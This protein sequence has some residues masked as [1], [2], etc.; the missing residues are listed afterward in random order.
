MI[1]L[2]VRPPIAF[3]TVQDAAEN[4]LTF[5]SS[6][7]FFKTRW[8]YGDTMNEAFEERVEEIIAIASMLVD[9]HRANERRKVRLIQCCPVQFGTSWMIGKRKSVT[10]IEVGMELF[11][12]PSAL[13]GGSVVSLCNSE[14]VRIGYLMQPDVD[15]IG[16]LMEGGHD[17]KSIVCEYSEGNNPDQ[18]LR[19]QKM[20]VLIVDILQGKD[21]K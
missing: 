11:L 8:F 21:L 18:K 13:N 10:D 1:K 2:H 4:T 14:G 20:N 15:Q 7:G 12:R 16:R 3:G 6:S 19:V 5:A 17:L 9:L